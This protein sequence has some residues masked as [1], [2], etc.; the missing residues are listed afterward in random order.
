MSQHN[1]TGSTNTVTH[2]STGQWDV[3]SRHRQ[4]PNLG[5][6]PDNVQ[7]TTFGAVPN[8]CSLD[9]PWTHA[10]TDTLVQHVNCFTVGGS[11][12]TNSF[13]ISDNS[14]A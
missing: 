4:F 6:S 9:V 7:V 13:L 11:P 8:W 1:S 10:G 3:I 2:G 12:V 14:L 5:V